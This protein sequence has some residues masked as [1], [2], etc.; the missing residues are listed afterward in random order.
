MIKQNTFSVVGRMFL[1]TVIALDVTAS[2]AH[3]YID[4]GAGSYAIQ[5]AIAG[6]AGILVSGKL[7]IT[8][9]RLFFAKMGD[10]SKTKDSSEN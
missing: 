1:L 3:A 7:I 5:V 8:K 9:I 4:P 10:R 6:L 2:Q